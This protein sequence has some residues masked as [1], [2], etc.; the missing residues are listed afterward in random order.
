[1]LT[2][3]EAEELLRGFGAG[4]V[5]A[6]EVMHL[7][8]LLID[9]DTGGDPAGLDLPPGFPAVV[10]AVSRRQAPP[11][12][13]CGPDVAVTAVPHPM[14]P[15]VTEDDPVEAA[16]RLAARVVGAPGAAL[17]LIEVLRAGIDIGVEEGLVIESLAYSMLQSGPEFAKWKKDRPEPLP[18]PA[19]GSAVTARRRGEVLELT[20][21]RPR[22]HNA[23]NRQMRDELCDALAVALAD[24]ACSV[25]LQ[26][27]GPS[28]CSGGDLDEFGTFPDPVTSHT[29]R[30]GRSPARLIAALRSR[31]TV[32]V[33]GSC[34]GS[35]IELPAF[36]GRVVARPGARMWLPE[37]AMGLIPGAGGTVSIARR[38]GRG[39]TAWM[40]ISGQAVDPDTALEWGLVDEISDQG[41]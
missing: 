23:Y 4:A 28:F 6:A 30:T 13:R 35:G 22:K 38:I 1:M 34:A 12:G 14:A 18:Q 26:G 39:R 21:N 11:L 31:T 20:L 27:A 5:D 3:S 36:A 41:D 25:L 37:L 17:T 8:V 32:V 9:M 15:W 29:V 2:V 7:R 33:H 40:G 16:S 19:H 24:P 10:V